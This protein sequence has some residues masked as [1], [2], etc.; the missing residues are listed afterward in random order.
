MR[1]STGS[2]V[3]RSPRVAILYC[4]ACRWVARAA[5]MSQ[6]ILTTFGSALGEVALVPAGRGVF[7]VWLDGECLHDRAAAGGF[8]ETKPIKQMIRDRIDPG[9]DLGHSE[10]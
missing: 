3:P 6:E 5:W 10:G 7:Q 2:E 1:Q 4:P 8:P 9:R